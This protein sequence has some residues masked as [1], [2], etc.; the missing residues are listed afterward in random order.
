MKICCRNLNFVQ[1]EHEENSSFLHFRA[2]SDAM[3]IY[4]TFNADAVRADEGCLLNIQCDLEEALILC[5]TW[6][7]LE[8]VVGFSVE[9]SNEGW[10]ISNNS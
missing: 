7:E 8:G 9:R 4:G 1:I 3:K 2:I 6:E 5:L 10:S